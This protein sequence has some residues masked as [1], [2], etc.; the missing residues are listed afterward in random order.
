MSSIQLEDR[1]TPA[2]MSLHFT[3]I[4]FPSSESQ[5]MRG[6]RWMTAVGATV[7]SNHSGGRSLTRC[8]AH[9][10][11]LAAEPHTAGGFLFSR[12]R[13]GRSLWTDLRADPLHV[14][15][16]IGILVGG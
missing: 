16:V 5:P 2:W 9:Q 6:S 8:S 14:H 15:A 10:L 4:S 11:G 13:S 1:A 7:P 3:I 12:S